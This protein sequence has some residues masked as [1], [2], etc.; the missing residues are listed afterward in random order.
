[1]S[2]EKGMIKKMDLNA[3]KAA[4]RVFHVPPSVLSDAVRQAKHQVSE[5]IARDGELFTADP[6]SPVG[7]AFGFNRPKRQAAEIANTSLVLQYASS[8]FA[9][10]FL[11][12]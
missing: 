4:R 12:G 8:R 10:S 9:K 11:Q 5:L 2:C 7:T 3:W 1:M 6:R